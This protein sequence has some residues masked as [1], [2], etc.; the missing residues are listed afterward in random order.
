MPSESTDAE[1]EIRDAWEQGNYDRAATRLVARYG[2]EIHAFLE[3]W[4]GDPGAASEA[5][6]L[7]AQN[8]W[9]GLPKFQWRCTA[10]SWAYAIARNAGRRLALAENRRRKHLV[11]LPD[12]LLSEIAAQ[13]RSRTDTFLKTE[14]KNKMQALRKRLPVEEQQILI[15]RV[16]R[17][18]SWTEIAMILSEDG[19]E[20]P[21]A[22]LHRLAARHRKRF[23]LAKERLRALAREEGLTS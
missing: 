10:Q 6:S 14:V 22:E 15:L 2:P 9:V 19:L 1:A 11:R 8:L 23:Q 7:F 5:F 18:L 13:S 3:V 17:Q 16:G 21:D 12:G 4:M 20:T